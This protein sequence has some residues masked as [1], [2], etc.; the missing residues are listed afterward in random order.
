MAG[1]STHGE[2]DG[3]L[4]GGEASI[5]GRAVVDF[6]DPRVAGSLPDGEAKL[7]REVGEE[8]EGPWCRTGGSSFVHGEYCD[9]SE[10]YEVCLFV[11]IEPYCIT[12]LRGM[13]DL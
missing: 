11:C 8:S 4:G 3:W 5:F 9:S 10:V 2:D 12:E 6:E 1:F 13:V 7:S